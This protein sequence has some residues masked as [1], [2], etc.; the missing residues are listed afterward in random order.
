[1]VVVVA[2]AASTKATAAD[3]SGLADDVGAPDVS[4]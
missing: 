1:M 2:A 4:W 3:G